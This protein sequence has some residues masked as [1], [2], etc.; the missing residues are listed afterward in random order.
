MLCIYGAGAYGIHSYYVL[1]QY[2]Q[3]VHAFFDR[4][5]SLRGYLMDGVSCFAMGDLA[6]LKDIDDLEMIVCVKSNSDDIMQNI[7]NHGV[8]N[9][10]TMQQYMRRYLRTENM[11]TKRKFDD[12]LFLNKMHKNF[13]RQFYKGNTEESLDNDL[14][15]ICLDISM[16]K[17][18]NE[19]FRNQQLGFARPIV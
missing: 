8:R 12:I 19:D 9:V 1:K 2:G 11:K 18:K 14:M 6:N 10:Y 16:R 3:K 7:K 13:C 15:S 5:S 4:N 17:E